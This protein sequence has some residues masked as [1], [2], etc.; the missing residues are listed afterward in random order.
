M[1]YI[2]WNLYR[3]NKHRLFAMV[4]KY[5]CGE[6]LVM[7]LNRIMRDRTERLSDAKIWKY[8]RMN[9]CTSKTIIQKRNEEYQP[10]RGTRRAKDI[11]LIKKPRYTIRRYL[12]IGAGRGWIPYKLGKKLRLR[13][14]DTVDVNDEIDPLL[15]RYLRHSTYNGSTLPY[16]ASTFELI[17]AVMVLHHVRNLSQ[18]LNSIYSV[19]KP[20]GMFIIRE[21]DVRDTETR[22]LVIIQHK[23]QSEL[24]AN[25]LDETV[26]DPSSSTYY[27]KYVPKSR[28]TKLIIK[29]GFMPYRIPRKKYPT[30]RN[31]PTKYYY[32]MFI[33]PEISE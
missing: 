31:N 13:H 11:M 26:D 24:Y 5:M 16:P 29:K 10:I 23:M 9:M 8:L 7:L 1:T 6:H 18:L 27:E 33:K 12:D 20:G 32:S 19:L 2:L 30:I 3:N 21:H 15:N 25:L 4:K 17:T 14:V 28:L 22:N